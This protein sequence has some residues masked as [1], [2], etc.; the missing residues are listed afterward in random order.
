MKSLVALTVLSVT[1]SVMQVTNAGAQQRVFAGMDRN[2]YPGDAALKQ[3]GRDFAFT[4]YW[5]NTPPGA[6]TNTWTGHREAVLKSGMGFAVLF[7]GRLYN[8]VH[9]HAAAMGAED[10]KSAVA[11]A[12]REGFHKETVIFLDQEQGGRLL[13]EQRAYLH[14]WIDGVTSAGFRAGV[15]CSG[16]AFKEGGGASVVTAEDIRENAGGRKIAYWIAN[17]SCPPAPG[18]VATKSAASASGVKFA[19]IWQYAQ[20]PVR[21]VAQACRKTY[22]STGACFAPGT[23]IDIDRNVAGSG[24]PSG[25]RR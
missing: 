12:E 25:G 14:A 19:D 1:L 17:D 10:A 5:L 20:S 2:V 23:K 6:K 21:P 24:D 16:I 3:L 15:Y 22:D 7:N 13:P 4:G 11:A 9:G 18:C 8:E